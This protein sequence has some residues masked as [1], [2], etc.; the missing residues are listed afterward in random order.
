MR[1]QHLAFNSEN[2]QQNK[3]KD[4]KLRENISSFSVGFAGAGT[5]RWF[6][7]GKP[8]QTQH[9]PMARGNPFE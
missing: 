8:A 5:S 4:I 6:F 3:S 9:L 1:C 7:T 2:I